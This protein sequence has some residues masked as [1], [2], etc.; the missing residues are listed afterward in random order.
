M[1]ED[2]VYREVVLNLRAGN[3]A[4]SAIKLKSTIRFDGG[5]RKSSFWSARSDTQRTYE[6]NEVYQILRNYQ[7]FKDRLER[8]QRL[9]DNA[10][11]PEGLELIKFTT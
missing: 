3:D 2:L 9:I 5:F 11:K 10:V 1:E 8:L 4:V 6:Q 7:T